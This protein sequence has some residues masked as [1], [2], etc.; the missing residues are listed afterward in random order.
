MTLTKNRRLNRQYANIAIILGLALF[1][2]TFYTAVF[3]NVTVTSKPLPWIDVKTN[4][5]A[6]GVL[7]VNCNPADPTDTRAG[8]VFSAAIS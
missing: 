3:A 2:I 5:R 1:G 4:T 8:G 7:A 6:A